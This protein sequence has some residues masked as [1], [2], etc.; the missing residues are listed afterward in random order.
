MKI[1]KMVN[2][3]KCRRILKDSQLNIHCNGG[4]TTGRIA[5]HL[6]GSVGLRTTTSARQISTSWVGMPPPI[7]TIRSGQIGGKV[8]VSRALTTGEA[9][10]DNIMFPDPS[11]DI[12]MAVA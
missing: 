3:I 9:G 12:G 7:R 5:P 11:E 10:N 8:A 6:R 2:A 4:A 1:K